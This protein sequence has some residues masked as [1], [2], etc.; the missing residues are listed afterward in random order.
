MFLKVESCS[1]SFPKI[2]KV[3]PTN[4]AD[5]I[6]NYHAIAAILHNTDF[7]KFLT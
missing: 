7:E 2:K 1:F 5:R 3:N 6:E 4:I